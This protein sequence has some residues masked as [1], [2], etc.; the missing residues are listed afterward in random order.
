MLNKNIHYSMLIVFLWSIGLIFDFPIYFLNSHEFSTVVLFCDVAG[1]T[2]LSE[3]LAL[4]G[5]VGAGMI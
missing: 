4:K 2:N 3:T 5:P 1:F